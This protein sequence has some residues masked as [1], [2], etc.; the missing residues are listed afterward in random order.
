MKRIV[1]LIIP[2]LI[3]GVMF[4]SCG[5]GS[6]YAGF[7]PADSLI[8]NIDQYV[9][10]T[11]KTE[12]LIAHVC[13]VDG[14]KMKLMSDGGEVIVVIPHDDNGFDHSLTKSRVIVQGLV[15]EKRIEQSYIDEKEAGK[16]LLCHVDQRPCKDTE[17]V[18][19]KIEAGVADSLSKQDIDRLREK[20]EQ[21]GRGYISIVSIVCTHYNVVAE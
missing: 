13:G 8:V 9:N 15:Q 16:A 12:G 17:W 2:A 18:N 20:M 4:T 10:K 21:Q 7:V 11:V 6:N 1:L 5:G 19:A 14:M 3:C